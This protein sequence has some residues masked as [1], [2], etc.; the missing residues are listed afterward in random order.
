MRRFAAAALL[1]VV[2]L[3]EAPAQQPSADQRLLFAPTPIG[4]PAPLDAG[5]P[6]PPRGAG[7][8]VRPVPVPKARPAASPPAA[9]VPT[10]RV[11]LSGAAP[12]AFRGEEGRALLAEPGQQPFDLSRGLDLGG[13]SLGLETGRGPETGSGMNLLAP[14][15]KASPWTD[16][17]LAEKRRSSSP[18]LGLSLS[19][20]TN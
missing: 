18:F 13:A 9:S 16:P 2:G 5:G 19:A 12:N 14:E 17:T 8:P 15:A 6:V 11:D 10:F 20:P 7:A 4:A 1:I 3:A